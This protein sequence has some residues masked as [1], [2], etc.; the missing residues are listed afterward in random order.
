MVILPVSEKIQNDFPVDL[1]H[2]RYI[3]TFAEIGKS[4]QIGQVRLHGIGTQT[5]LQS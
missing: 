4:A 3:D 1:V 2:I 5:P